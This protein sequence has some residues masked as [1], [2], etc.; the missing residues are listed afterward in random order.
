M[1]KKAVICISMFFAFCL[2][3]AYADTQN[4]LTTDQKI[5]KLKELQKQELN[6]ASQT[7]TDTVK[8]PVDGYVNPPDTGTNSPKMTLQKIRKQV[9][10]ENDLAQ[11]PPNMPQKIAKDSIDGY[12]DVDTLPNN[13]PNP[14]TQ[15][16]QQTQ[17]TAPSAPTT[18]QQPVV[19]P[20]PDDSQSLNS[21][22]TS[23]AIADKEDGYVNPEAPS[24]PVTQT[25]QIQPQHTNIDKGTQNFT[26]PQIDESFQQPKASNPP[27]LQD[28][29]NSS[30]GYVDNENNEGYPSNSSISKL[31]NRL[32]R[33]N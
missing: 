6:S 21:P 31:E 26:P 20:V 13:T 24:K 33:V 19:A 30:D 12:A 28:S 3:T 27:P 22:V 1:S 4:N 7:A 15:Q 32:N 8:D 14:N 11:P 18:T 25:N 5:N 16:T 10:V 17:Q 2:I 23:S 9:G 29:K